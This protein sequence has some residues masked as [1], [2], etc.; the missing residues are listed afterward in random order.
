MIK[1]SKPLIIYRAFDKRCYADD[2]VKKGIIRLGNLKYYHTIEDT[3][4]Q[5]KT[6]GSASYKFPD[7]TLYANNGN[8]KYILSCSTSEVDLSF[9]RRK[10][11]SFVVQIEDVDQLKYD[12]KHSIEEI[13][14][15]LVGNLMSGA[16]IYDKDQSREQKL[17]E[18]ENFKLTMFQKPSCFKNECEYRIVSIF[19]YPVPQ[20]LLASHIVLKLNKRLDYAKLLPC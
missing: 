15:K 5:D 16:V 18:S 19:D 13:Q 20:A 11:G 14:L 9:L 10:M 2:F 17:S 1:L 3:T 6:E 12:I 7:G 8:H 4:R